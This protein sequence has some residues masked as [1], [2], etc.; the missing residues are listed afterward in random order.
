MFAR[1]HDERVSPLVQEVVVLLE[2][3][4]LDGDKLLTDLCEHEPADLD[5]AEERLGPAHVLVG[6]DERRHG[7]EHLRDLARVAHRLIPKV[8]CRLDDGEKCRNFCWDGR[9]GSVEV[10]SRARLSRIR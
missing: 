8:G 4:K 2:H 5:E 9:D 1:R 7:V 6:R 3:G 10:A